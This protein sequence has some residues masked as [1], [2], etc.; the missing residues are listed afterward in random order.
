MSTLPDHIQFS[1]EYVRKIDSIVL[2][3]F[4]FLKGFSLTRFI[5]A[6]QFELQQNKGTYYAAINCSI[7]SLLK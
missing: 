2:N 5:I 4:Q 6:P 1:H 7:C 3:I